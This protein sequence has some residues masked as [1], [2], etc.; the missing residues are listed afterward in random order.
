MTYCKYICLRCVFNCHY[1]CVSVVVE[2]KSDVVSLPL[3]TTAA[4]AAAAAATT[5]TSSTTTTTVIIIIIIII[6]ISRLSTLLQN[7]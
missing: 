7:M 1:S 5:T 6:I 2:R 3:V 4:A